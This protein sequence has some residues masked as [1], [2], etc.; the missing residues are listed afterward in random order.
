MKA[1]SAA[2]QTHP[3][4][5]ALFL[6]F[7][8]FL[9]VKQLCFSR[10]HNS[11]V[12]VCLSRRLRVSTAAPQHEA[13]LMYMPLFALNKPFTHWLAVVIQLIRGPCGPPP[14]HPPPRS[15]WFFQ[16]QSRP[17]LQSPPP[18]GVPLCLRPQAL[19]CSS[20]V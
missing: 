13:Y 5:F 18:H 9:F 3:L 20:C 16:V 14:H 1:C 7:F 19:V 6:F 8:L 4:D 10:S 17:Q 2:S 11:I 15:L 12:I